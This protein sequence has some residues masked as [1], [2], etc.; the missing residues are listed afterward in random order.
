MDPD[1]LRGM[2]NHQYER[3][4]NMYAAHTRA[5]LQE[6]ASRDLRDLQVTESMLNALPPVGEDGRRRYAKKSGDKQ[7]GIAY[8]KREFKKPWAHGE[9]MVMWVEHG[10]I[11]HACLRYEGT[12]WPAS[13]APQPGDA[14]AMNDSHINCACTLERLPEPEPQPRETITSRL[15][16]AGAV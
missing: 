5:G 9:P 10:A 15:A 4:A 1:T 13:Q 7:K 3:F 6:D 8:K 16:Q 14:T 12:V 2:L 11:D